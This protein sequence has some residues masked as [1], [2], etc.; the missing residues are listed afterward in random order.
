MEVT[1]QEIMLRSYQQRMVF[2]T[3]AQSNRTILRATPGPGGCILGGNVQ[4]YVR[5]RPLLQKEEEDEV[6][7]LSF[8]TDTNQVCFKGEYCDMYIY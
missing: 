8:T 7:V 2:S 5:C 6:S 1:Y 4:V 3:P